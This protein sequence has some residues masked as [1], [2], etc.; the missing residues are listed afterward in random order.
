MTR[1]PP[2]PKGDST[3]YYFV[4]RIYFISLYQQS[5]LEYICLWRG[6]SSLIWL[7]SVLQFYPLW[8]WQPNEKKGSQSTFAKMRD[9]GLLGWGMLVLRIVSC[10]FFCVVCC[11]SFCFVL[12]C[13]V[14]HRFFGCFCESYRLRE[15][16]VG[17]SARCAKEAFGKRATGVVSVSNGPECLSY[18]FWFSCALWR[19]D[20]D[21]FVESALVLFFFFFIFFLC[22]CCRVLVFFFVV[23]L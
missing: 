13:S 12:F 19:F 4:C 1:S 9:S 17:K 15:S 16:C 7:L 18:W 8:F 11:D 21:R 6:L 2:R 5:M 14:P 20:A 23:P 22:F 3:K 10:C